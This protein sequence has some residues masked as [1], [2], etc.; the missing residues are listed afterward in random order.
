MYSELEKIINKAQEEINPLIQKKAD[1]LNS[2]MYSD[3][4]KKTQLEKIEETKDAIREKMLKDITAVLD[5]KVA[6]VE[7]KGGGIYNSSLFDAET[8]CKVQFIKD[9]KE[10]L[11]AGEVKSL[12]ANNT[13]NYVVLK[14]LEPIAEKYGI[15]INNLKFEEISSNEDNIKQL[16]KTILTWI[17]NKVDYRADELMPMSLAMMIQNEK[18]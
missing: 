7:S 9:M 17:K 4:Y 11:S 13:E 16:R 14:Y 1:V 5:A 6:E 12:I 18:L 10:N 3:S 15:V 2:D 8:A